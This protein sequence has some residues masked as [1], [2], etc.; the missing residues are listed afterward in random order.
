[1]SFEGAMTAL[2]TPMRHGRVDGDAIDRLVEAQIAAGIDALV[3]VGTTG[4]SATLT[5]DEHVDVVRAVVTAARGRVPVIAGA[6]ANATAE[7]IELTRACEAAGA[8]GLLHV[9]PYY[10][11]PNQEGLYRHFKAVAEATRLPVILYNVPGRTGCD[12][13]PETI[14]R[15]AERDNIVGVK[16]ATGNLLRASDILRRCGDRMI[17]LSGDDFTAFPLYAVG[18][19]GVI[20]VV[21]NVMAAEMA[22]M[23]DAFA[24]GDLARARTLHQRILPLT[25]L[26]FA[27]PSPSP[28][29][30]ALA[31]L[32]RM[33]AEV[34]LPLVQVSDGLRDRLRRQLEA[35]GLL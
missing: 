17:L 30:A 5:H 10:N 22:G 33:S 25:E 3:A 6:G 26:L 9:T 24:A 4:E 12:L 16:E 34:R 13:L 15:L 29:K 1:M 20:S 19:R 23:W 27:E 35:D 28:T 18:A 32:G 21:S 14:A 7:A 11:R 31:L 2:V 8:Q